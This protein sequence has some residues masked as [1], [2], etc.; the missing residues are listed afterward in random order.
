VFEKVKQ[1]LFLI[2]YSR[3][4][5]SVVT[6]LWNHLK[7][8]CFLA[9]WDVIEYNMTWF[10]ER[11]DIIIVSDWVS[12]WVSEF[13]GYVMARTG[14]IRLDYDISIITDQPAQLDFLLAHW[15]NSPQ[16][17]ISLYSNTLFWFQVSPFLLLLQNVACL[18]EK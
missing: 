4:T 8:S 3:V 13:F 17:N 16:I 12:E 2:R 15:N 10:K 7:C 6:T 18:A 14:Y 5:L 11:M 1:F 9:H